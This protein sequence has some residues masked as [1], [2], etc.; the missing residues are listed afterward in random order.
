MYLAPAF[1][2]DFEH[3]FTVAPVVSMSKITDFNPDK[4]QND[5]RM[6]VQYAV[7][8]NLARF[9]KDVRLGVYQVGQGGQD[10][11]L[12]YEERRLE[13]EPGQYFFNWDG[14]SLIPS[15][16]VEAVP[17]NLSDGDYYL[18][19]TAQDD[20]GNVGEVRQGFRIDRAPP[21]VRLFTSDKPSFDYILEDDHSNYLP[22]PHRK[23]NVDEFWKMLF[24]YSPEFMEYRQQIS[25]EMQEKWFNSINNNNNLFLM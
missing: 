16:T 13:L 24:M 8:D 25:R 11:L 18:L 9:C 5:S 10:D 6:R 2:R 14:R 12:V 4:P 1:L 17:K 7:T 20:G 19:I 21:E 15:A 22:M 3:S 23:C